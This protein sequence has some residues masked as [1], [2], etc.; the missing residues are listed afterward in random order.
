MLDFSKIGLPRA[1]YLERSEI[2]CQLNVAQRKAR[3]T[4]SLEINGKTWR[5]GQFWES[6][7]VGQRKENGK[8]GNLTLARTWFVLA[9]LVP[10]VHREVSLAGREPCSRQH[11]GL[12]RHMGYT[13]GYCLTFMLVH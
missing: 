1:S 10:A 11:K 12:W 7:K 3:L 9:F 8:K 13:F 2:G 5:F 6:G 4:T